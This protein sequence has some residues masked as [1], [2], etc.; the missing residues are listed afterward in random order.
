MAAFYL[1]GERGAAAYKDRLF[2]AQTPDE[3]ISIAREMWK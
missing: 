2:K 1:K 3:I